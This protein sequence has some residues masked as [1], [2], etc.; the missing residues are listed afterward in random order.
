MTK[1]SFPNS[2]APYPSDKTIVDLFLEQVAR[3]P[4]D[5]AI[6]CADQ[7]LTY[8]ELNERA[9]QIAAHL[10]SLGV[11]PGELVTIFMDHSIEV[12]VAIYG[13]LKAGAAYVP[14]D[15]SSPKERVA[16]MLRDITEGLGG[17]LPAL[18]TQSHLADRLPIGSS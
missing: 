7:S 15:P 18:V 12:V 13:V 3:T 17:I 16:F 1:N 2:S 4:N 10:R 8:R 6:R 11:G 14:V 9:N 5:E